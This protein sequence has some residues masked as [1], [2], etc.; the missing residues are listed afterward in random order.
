MRVLI[1]DD[2]PLARSRLARLLGQQPDC[3]TVVEAENGEQAI[4]VCNQQLP[5]VVLMDI[6]MPVMDGLQTA[7]HLA[8]FDEAPAVI[9]CTAY[10]DY[11]LEAFDA[12][13]VDYLL[14]PVNKEKLSLALAKAKK[15]NRVQLTA[16]SAQQAGTES[17]RGH[18][19]AKSSRGIELIAVDN[20]R[21]F[22][23][24]QK[25]VTVW[26][27]ADGEQKHVLID[28][29]LKDLEQMLGDQFVRIHR[30]AL[31]AVAHIQGFEKV[32][33][34]IY[35]KLSGIDRGPQVS[36]RYQALVRELVQQL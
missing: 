36:R 7:R 5:D 31:A 6:R 27:Q 1:V 33:Q 18:I 11:A 3:D 22:I 15:L 14:K 10:N 25:Y 34:A 16:L 12:N 32:E 9:F 35:L 30:N 2:E 29:S 19:A 4:I 8:S 28:D 24:D 26:F 13:A 20:I 17:H 23:A 21:Y